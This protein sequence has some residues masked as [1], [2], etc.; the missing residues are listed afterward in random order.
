[1]DKL[2][3]QRGGRADKRLGINDVSRDDRTSCESAGVDEWTAVEVWAELEHWHVARVCGNV[4]EGQEVE[5]V[6]V[7][8]GGPEPYKHGRC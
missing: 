7:A 5:E 6:G 8:A 2:S 4:A 3:L 1:V